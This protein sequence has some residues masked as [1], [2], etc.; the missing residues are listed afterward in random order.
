[1]AGLCTGVGATAAVSKGF[2]SSISKGLVPSLAGATFGGVVDN[3]TALFGG[4]VDNGTAFLG[5]EVDKR[6]F[7]CELPLAGGTGVGR[8]GGLAGA[9]AGSVF[10]QR[11]SSHSLQQSIIIACSAFRNGA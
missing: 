9:A 2:V 1:M 5:G 8:G 10:L 11:D 4:V 7:V 3:G 6:G